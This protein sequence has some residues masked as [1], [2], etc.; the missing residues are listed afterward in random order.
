MYAADKAS[1][2]TLE[3]MTKYTKL[4]NYTQT[5]TTCSVAKDIYQRAKYKTTMNSWGHW[6]TPPYDDSELRKLCELLS[7]AL[8]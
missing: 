4:K 2:K 1:T 8:H 6:Y 7:V 5:H 3:P